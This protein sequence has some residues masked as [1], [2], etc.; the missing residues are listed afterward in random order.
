M[1]VCVVV[2]WQKGRE[3]KV[4][5]AHAGGLTLEQPQ[6]KEYAEMILFVLKR[7]HGVL[8]W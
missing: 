8:R 2:L 6:N 7:K 3:A 5:V 1:V 4:D